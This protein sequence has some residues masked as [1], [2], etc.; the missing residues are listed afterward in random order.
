MTGMQLFSVKLH[1]KMTTSPEA[2]VSIYIYVYINYSII[3][4]RERE[5]DQ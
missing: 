4:A 2:Y 3:K 1:K 5:R